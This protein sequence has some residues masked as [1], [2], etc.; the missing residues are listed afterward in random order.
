MDERQAV[1]FQLGDNIFGIPVSNVQEIIKTP[2]I[3]VIPNTPE[4]FEGVINLRG[5]VIPVLGLGKKL[6]LR[7]CDSESSR[8]IIINVGANSAGIIVDVVCDVL[9]IAEDSIETDVNLCDMADRAINGIAKLD[10][11]LIILLNLERILASDGVFDFEEIYKAI[12]EF[13][14]VS[15]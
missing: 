5:R 12:E 3:T 7:K 1:L 14:N 4:F 15:S 11:R 8:T 13:Y 9:K 6:G 2:P 10:H